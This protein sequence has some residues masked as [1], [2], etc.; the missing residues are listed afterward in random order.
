[1]SDMCETIVFEQ[2]EAAFD[3]FAPA[4]P[5]IN[6]QGLR[7]MA[8]A[9]ASSSLVAGAASDGS[10]WFMCIVASNPKLEVKNA[11]AVIGTWTGTQFRRSQELGNEAVVFD[12]QSTF[13]PVRVRC[14]DKDN[15][16]VV[17][18]FEIDGEFRVGVTNRLP[19][20]VANPCESER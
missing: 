12:D 2:N 4:N 16:A 11:G 15:I 14:G 18:A 3:G 5:L 8:V 20:Q 9:H 10:E 17:M 1:M 6:V 13:A 7:E 19:S